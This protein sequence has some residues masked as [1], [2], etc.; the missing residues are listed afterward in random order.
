MTERDKMRD[1]VWGAMLEKLWR[2][3][4]CFSDLVCYSVCADVKTRI[5]KNIAPRVFI[6]SLIRQEVNER[7]SSKKKQRRGDSS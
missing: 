5:R 4:T 2:D 6:A 1:L 3:T 7:L